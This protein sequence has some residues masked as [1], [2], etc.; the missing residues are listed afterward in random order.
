MIHRH[1]VRP[2]KTKKNGLDDDIYS[3]HHAHHHHH[4]QYIFLCRT[5]MAIAP[6][7][8]RRHTMNDGW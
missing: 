6:T 4:H 3:C 8:R 1:I 5:A 2:L 7:G